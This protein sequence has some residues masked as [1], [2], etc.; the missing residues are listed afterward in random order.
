MSVYTVSQINDAIK[1]AIGNIYDEQ[2]SVEGE[3]SNFKISNDNLFCTLKDGTS[4]INVVSWG[5]GKYDVKL[6]NGDKVYVRGKLLTYTKTG[7]YSLTAQKIEKKGLGNLHK[8][9]EE[10][11]KEYQNKGYFDEINKSKLPS[12][13][14][15]IGILTASEG[16][17]LQ[18]ILYVLKENKYSGKVIIKNCMVQGTQ[19][20]KSVSD[21][22]KELNNWSDDDQKLDIILIA[23]GGGSFEDLMGYSDP[24]ILESIYNSN[25]CTVSAIGH[26]VDFMLSDYVADIRAPT[27]SI[28]GEIIS[29]QQRN[30]IEEF[31][32]L[33]E[34]TKNNFKMIIDNKIDTMSMKLSY[35]LNK[36]TDLKKSIKSPIDEIN[37]I[38]NYLSHVMI[39]NIDKKLQRLK[40]LEIRLEQNDINKMLNLGYTLLSNGGIIIDSVNDVDIGN[41]LKLRFKDGEATI[42]I[43][44]IKKNE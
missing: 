40:D 29:K 2:I 3:I 19:C 17:A 24:E 22:I 4:A 13:I 39:A 18:D 1:D 9:Y 44:S 28:A 42:L 30:Q 35:N 7:T 31:M 32:Q 37:N 25:I 20:P 10:I 38:E 41:K 5:F 33:K 26:E 43:K 8:K 23:R 6:S 21:G 34:H 15:R 11:K 14:N 16:A 27:P 12:K 36:I